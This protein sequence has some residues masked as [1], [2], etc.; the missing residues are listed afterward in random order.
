MS[1]K[2]TKLTNKYW[3]IVRVAMVENLSPLDVHYLVVD[4]YAAGYN[5]ACKMMKSKIAEM[6]DTGD[7]Q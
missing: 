6:Q 2:L 5:Q 1:D 3:K 7:D 4:A